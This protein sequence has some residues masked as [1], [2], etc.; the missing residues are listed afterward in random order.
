[1]YTGRGSFF[2]S[3]ELELELLSGFKHTTCNTLLTH[4]P[5]TF[6]TAPDFE[7]IGVCPGSTGVFSPVHVKVPGVTCTLLLPFW[8][9]GARERPQLPLLFKFK[10][11]FQ[12]MYNNCNRGSYPCRA[13][14]S[15]WLGYCRPAANQ[16]QARWWQSSR[17]KRVGQSRKSIVLV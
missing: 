12:Y 9:H 8:R 3:V 1:V 14:H 7:L 13:S 5:V 16:Q 15:P 4:Y 6:P 2:L 10:F 11:K 17:A